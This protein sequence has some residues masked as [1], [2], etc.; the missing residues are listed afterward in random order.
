MKGYKLR[1]KGHFIHY[2]LPNGKKKKLY[3]K[4]Y[5]G[6]KEFELN[7]TQADMDRA[8]GLGG[9]GT[10]MAC[11]MAVCSEQHA[12]S[13]PHPFELVEWTDSMAYFITEMQLGKPAK[14][15]A[16]RHNDKVAALFDSKAGRRELRSRLASE[17]E[18]VVRLSPPSKRASQVGKTKPQGRATGTRSHVSGDRTKGAYRRLRRTIPILQ[19]AQLRAA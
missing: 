19:E 17:G 6:K 7:V 12:G 15:I 13:V 16:Y 3:A 9:V 10:T 11:M 2:V 4:V 5:L 18:I 1:P 8:E 14:C